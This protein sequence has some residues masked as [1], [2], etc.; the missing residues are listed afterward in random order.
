MKTSQAGIDLIK[1]YEGVRLQAYQDS[2][3]V[4]TIGVGH[5]RTAVPGMMISEAK[6]EELLREDLEQAEKDVERLVTVPL[7]QHQFDA[8]V[9]FVFNL[10]AGNFASS[11]L[12]KKLNARD[13]AGASS[14]FLR[15]DMA[16]GKKLR[17][18]K[19]RREAERRLFLS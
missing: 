13:F 1:H 4:W 2:V 19:A 6:A 14:E 3:G 16:G 18:L 11:T 7:D 8:L 10:G 9:S 5:T 15:W 17:G 12:L